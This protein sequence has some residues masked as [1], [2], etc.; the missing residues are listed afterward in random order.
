[1][2]VPYVVESEI[3]QGLLY[4]QYTGSLWERGTAQMKDESWIDQ[5]K[6]WKPE[7]KSFQIKLLNEGAQTQSQ[8]WLLNSMWCDWQ[9]IKKMKETETSSIQE[10]IKDPWE[11][12]LAC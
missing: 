9:E 12:E 5:Y 4:R 6:Q 3:K 8:Q 10:W 2:Q 11:D 1:M 7:L